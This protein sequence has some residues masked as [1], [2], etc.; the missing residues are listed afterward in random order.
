VG[1][2]V[3]LPGV[4]AT[5]QA[6]PPDLGA[7]ASKVEE[8]M[9][10]RVRRDHFSGSILI[11][12]DGKIL[13]ARG[14]G[15]ANL[16]YDVPNTPH[17]K[18]RLGSITKQ[19]TAMAILIL[20]ERGKLKVEDKINKY[21]PD[22]PKAWDEI[23]IRHLLTHTSGIPNYTSYPEFL[24]TLPVRVT[25]KELIGKFRDKPLDFKPGEK[26]KYSN[27]GYVVLG[28]VIETAAGQSYAS[29]LNEAIF[30]PL[31]MKDTGYDSAEPIIK[32]RAAGYTRRLGILLSNCD[33]VDMSIPHAAGALYSTV[34][35]L[36]KWDQALYTEKLVP[37]KS[38]EAM[39]APVN[40]NYGYGWLID[41][42]QGRTRYS[43]G[44]GI[45]GF[46]TMIERYP[47]PKLLVVALSNLENSPVGAIGDDLAAIALGD[48]YVIPREPKVAKVDPAL[49]DAY[50]GRYEAD[51][52]GKG[53][54]VITVT[55]DSG[56]LL[57]QRKGNARAV[58]VPES[59]A[60]FYIKA[61]D[62]EARFVRDPSGKVASLVL[63]KDGEEITA[64]R[65]PDE[66][67][68]GTGAKP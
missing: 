9:D 24:K 65:L 29:F 14:Y 11:A 52:P 53:K 42:K 18:F 21:V 30:A 43:H 17:T 15:M 2:V 8:Y 67:R 22:A 44:G 55:R 33:Y 38:L 39:F 68:V 58:L 35:D 31:G 59:D 60:S 19:F 12:R 51:V 54:E 45:M 40:D 7:L 32:H 10:A 41:K 34:E 13:F 5:A 6:P 16:E 47:E 4:A 57:C 63:I 37:R 25:L 28:Q 61:S 66:A 36:L 64:R 62:A 20:Q 48:K 49:Y 3:L 23:T 50:A 27:S 56:R 26:Y 1:L 46:A